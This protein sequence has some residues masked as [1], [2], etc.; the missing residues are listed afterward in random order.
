MLVTL[1][2]TGLGLQLGGGLGPVSLSLSGFYPPST[3]RDPAGSS[4]C[5][6]LAAPVTGFYIP[7]TADTGSG[8]PPKSDL[9]E[10]VQSIKDLSPP[11]KAQSPYCPR[12]SVC[13]ELQQPIPAALALTKTVLEGKLHQRQVVLFGQ[14]FS[15]CH[16]WHASRFPTAY[17]RGLAGS[18]YSSACRTPLPLPTDTHC[19]PRSNTSLCRD[20]AEHGS[21]GPRNLS[22]RYLA[23]RHPSLLELE[24]T[25]RIS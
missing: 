24:Q 2:Q 12:Y 18:K 1:L 10:A 22:Q 4:L 14:G 9:S 7:Q 13:F 6:M 16:P 25:K 17:A 3:C 8:Q 21:P 20:A 15:V 5:H 23:A 19:S 11:C